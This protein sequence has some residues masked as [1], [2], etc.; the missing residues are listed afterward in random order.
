M[1]VVASAVPSVAWPVVMVTMVVVTRPVISGL[2]G[3]VRVVPGLGR[4][5][6]VELLDV[7]MVVMV[8]MM[9]MVMVMVVVGV[10]ASSAEAAK[11]RLNSSESRLPPEKN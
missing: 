1:V 11:E 7:V 3:L 2:S 6:V 5:Q 4:A 9:V 8:V 10:A